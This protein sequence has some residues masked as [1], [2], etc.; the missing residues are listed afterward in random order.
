MTV[1]A[2]EAEVHEHWVRT[3]RPVDHVAP[4]PLTPGYRGT[5]AWDRPTRVAQPESCPECGSCAGRHLR[6]CSRRSQS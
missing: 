6:V 5:P 1:W 3:T 4:R 2:S